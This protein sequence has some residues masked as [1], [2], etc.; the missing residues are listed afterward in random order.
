MS[1]APVLIR[2]TCPRDCYD[3]CGIMVSTRNGH[4]VKVAGD[5]A[6]PVSRGT[7]CGKCAVAYN[8][9]WLSPEQRLLR[10]LLRKGPK[11]SGNFAPC[12]WDEALEK[13]AERLDEIVRSAGAQSIYHTH[14]TGTC[15]LL[16][17]NFPLRFLN[18]LGAVEVDPDTVC[19]KAG[20]LALQLVFGD[21]LIGFDPRTEKHSK[22]ILVWGANPSSAAPHVNKHW[23]KSSN[24]FRIVID[25]IRHPT[26][27][28]ADLHLQPRPGSDGA[29]AFALLHVMHREN[30]LD[31]GYLAAHVLGWEV[32]GAQLHATT[33]D[34][35]EQQTGVPADKIV[36]AAVAYGN[37]PS[38]LWLG[39]GL[40][41]QP[42]GGK[43]L[44]RVQLTTDCHRQHRKDG[45]R[46]PLYE[47]FRREWHRH[48]AAAEPDRHRRREPHGPGSDPG[49]PEPQSCFVY[50]E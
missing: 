5:R 46:L 44:S 8:G 43:R 15:S 30:L 11:G 12:S 27:A 10:P 22:C 50:V 2:T 13:I 16:A 48:Q 29:L 17:G 33:P 42:T 25:P 7:L 41:R 9:I 21:S 45:W 28:A 49:R 38:L 32:V 3:A 23:L 26:A 36:A 18:R 31:R 1:E 14:Y 37:G 19:N 24:A 6:H 20:H 47:R 34:W 39:Q 35:G 40:Q 4:M